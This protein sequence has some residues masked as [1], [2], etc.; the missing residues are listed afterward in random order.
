MKGVT[1]LRVG[2]DLCNN[3]NNKLV[4]GTRETISRLAEAH[5]ERCQIYLMEL[6]LKVLGYFR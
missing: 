1:C 3:S 4:C 5:L 6:V 2:V